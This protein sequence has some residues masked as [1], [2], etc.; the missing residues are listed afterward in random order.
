MIATHFPWFLKQYDG[1]PHGIQRADAARYFFM[2]L[3]GGVYADMDYEPLVNFWPSLPG[4]GLIESPYQ[5]NEKVQNSL[6]SSSAKHRFWN[7]T[8]DALVNNFVYAKEDILKSTGPA[9]LD[10]AVSAAEKAGVGYNVLPCENFQRVPL[11]SAGWNS[12]FLSFL[13]RE[14][15]GRSPFVKACG[16]VTSLNCHYGIH[17]NTVTYMN[18]GLFA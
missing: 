6:M 2:W 3:Y 1:Y 17:H 9:M 11:G 13:A 4:V 14:I 15:M 8:F 18:F 16:S 10:M 12:P 7:Y 5:Y